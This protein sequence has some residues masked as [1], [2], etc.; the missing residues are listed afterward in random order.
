MKKN[1]CIIKLHQDVKK[2]HCIIKNTALHDRPESTG[3]SKSHL[4]GASNKAWD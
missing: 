1:R 2:N 3:R 4:L